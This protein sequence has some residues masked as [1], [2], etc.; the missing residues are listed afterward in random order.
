MPLL[1]VKVIP[2][3]RRTAIGGKYGGGITVYVAAPPEG[4]ASKEAVIA[5]VAEA[6]GVRRQ[7]V[8]I[9]RGRGQPRKVVEV[10]GLSEPQLTEKLAAF[11]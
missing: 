6:F 3:S 7:D 2:G 9:V 4:G 10:V 8:S 1:T 11:A 5:L